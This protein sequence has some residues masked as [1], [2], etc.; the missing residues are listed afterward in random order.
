MAARLLKAW[1]HLLGGRASISA[2]ARTAL[3]KLA[4]PVTDRVRS[5]SPATPTHLDAD[6]GGKRQSDP[7]PWP[8]VHRKRSGG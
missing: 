7:Y 3:R 8:D 1:Q 6:I 5:I 2:V 4:E